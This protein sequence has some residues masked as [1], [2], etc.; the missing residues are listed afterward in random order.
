[1]IANHI[2][3]NRLSQID[4][5]KFTTNYRRGN[6]DILGAQISR[7]LNQDSEFISSILSL[8]ANAALDAAKTPILLH[9]FN[10]NS[11]TAPTAFM[12]IISGVSKE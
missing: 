5:L 1:M 11:F 7:V 3:N 12:L 8:F 9:R 6:S 10:L 2:T 4:E